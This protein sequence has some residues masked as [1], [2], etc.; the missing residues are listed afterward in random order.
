VAHVQHKTEQKWT[1]ADYRTW[2]D[3]ERWELIDG[4]AFLM[5]PAPTRRHQEISI[6]LA[7]QFHVHLKG[8]WCKVYV[9][10]FDVRLSA[11]EG[12]DD[13]A[14]LTVVQPDIVVVCDPSKLDE[15]GCIGVPDLIV[16]I[17]SPSTAERDL[18]DKFYLYQRV[19]VK[20]YWLVSQSDSTLMVFKLNAIGEYGRPEMYGARDRVD[21]PMLGDLVVDLADVFAS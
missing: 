6:E 14:I 1:Y 21:V 20:E 5:S 13:E 19:G 17:L 9:A 8:K 4:E 2:P 16:E 18:K 11:G 12:T 3:D 15:R 10:P 7:S